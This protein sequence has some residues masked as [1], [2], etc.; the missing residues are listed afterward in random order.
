ML[1]VL[2]VELEPPGAVV[3]DVDVPPVP[4]IPVALVA[5]V[6]L[7]DDIAVPV[8][9][10]ESVEPVVSVPVVMFV[11]SCLVQAKAK[12]IRAATA[13]AAMDFFIVVISP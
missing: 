8:V 13:R 1:V 11:F 2:D 10:V 12:T 4:V 5:V 3:V 7:V 6:L 9:V